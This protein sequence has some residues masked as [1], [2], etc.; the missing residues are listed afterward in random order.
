[1]KKLR[2]KLFCLW[3]ELEEDKNSGAL[4]NG[5]PTKSNPFTCCIQ[6]YGVPDEQGGWIRMHKMF[7]TTI[8]D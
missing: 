5:K 7:N 4:A 6:E 1:M 3:G 8:K 2:E